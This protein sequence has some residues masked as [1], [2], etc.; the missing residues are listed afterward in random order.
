MA[1]NPIS[2]NANISTVAASY[3]KVSVS[4]EFTK[5]TVSAAS[6][7]M[8]D[9][10]VYEKSNADEPA[11]AAN[12]ANGPANPALIEKLKADAEERTAALRGIVE[13]LLL[14]QGGA[15][16]KAGSLA[17]MYRNLE[18]D[19]ETRL[20]AQ[21]D[22]AEDGYWGVEQTSDRILEFA[23][24]MAGDNLELAQKML[25]AVKEGFKQAGI[26][27]GED[28][29]DISK[30]TMEATYKKFDEWINGLGGNTEKTQ[31]PA[32]DA[33]NYGASAVQATTTSVKVSA[34]YTKASVSAASI[35]VTQ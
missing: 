13:E 20:Q 35:D 10:V 8:S 17:D 11:K 23:K 34:S 3:E 25:G 21:K 18:V 12:G 30:Q 4:A 24:G 27:W 14:K 33:N 19:E 2:T 32:T 6:A 15:L 28:L 31:E 22:I 9:A 26:E 7:D 1:I 5:K 16:F 29:P